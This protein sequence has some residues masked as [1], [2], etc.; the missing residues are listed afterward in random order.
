MLFI[1]YYVFVLL[2]LVH[3]ARDKGLFSLHDLAK[4]VEKH[5]LTKFPRTIF[6]L[7]H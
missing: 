5:L 1:I 7:S 6:R 3:I 2:L 4:L